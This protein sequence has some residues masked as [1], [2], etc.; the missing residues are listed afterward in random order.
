MQQAV[1]A[2]AD[3]PVA[4]QAP[5]PGGLRPRPGQ[6]GNR[7]AAVLGHLAIALVALWGAS[8][9]IFLA[10]QLLPGDI[11]AIKA[12]TDASQAEIE[13]LRESLGLNRPLV[14]RYWEWFSGVLRLD[15]GVSSLSH[16]PIGADLLEKMAITGPAAVGSLLLSLVV[17]LPLGV[18]AAARRHDGVGQTIS[19]LTQLGVAIPAFVVGLVLVDLF[20]IRAKLLPATGFPI[21][22][23]ADPAAAMRSLWLPIV[24][25]AIPQAAV[26]I[27]FIRSATI[28]VLHR[29]HLRTARAQGLS[30]ARALGQS[31]RM[32]ALP[33]SGVIALDFAGLITGTVIVERVFA[34][35]GVGQ[36]LLQSIS[37]RD[38]TVVQ[39]V[40]MLMSS[41][42]IV[43]M[44]LAT[45]VQDFLDPRLRS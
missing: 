13:A 29:D 40:L 11:A 16:R 33:L 6:R 18:L 1:A 28:D 17:A 25:L 26:F 24:T 19:A 12:G 43:V 15:F 45:M 41:A 34:L 9:V 31:W 23:W 4:G 21:D 3:H 38:F 8:I 7:W 32:I 10:L 44:A 14:V 2:S 37:V 35:P 39:S 27:R 22:G 42:I 36:L 5:A 20:A 30:P